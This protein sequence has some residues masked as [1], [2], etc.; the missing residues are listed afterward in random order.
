MDYT[1]LWMKIS[2]MGISKRKLSEM[3][4]LS[5]ASVSY[6]GRKAVRSGTIDRICRALGCGVEDVVR[7]VPD[8]T[9][10]ERVST[11]PARSVPAENDG[12]SEN[13]EKETFSRVQS[14]KPEKAAKK[15]SAK[16]PPKAPPEKYTYAQKEA[17]Y[18]ALGDK[19]FVPMNAYLTEHDVSYTALRDGTGIDVGTLVSFS[20]GSKV[21]S[22]DE[23]GRIVRFLECRL[24]DVCSYTE[25]ST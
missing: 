13:L 11:R 9:V 12:A 24:S 1:P 14:S 6:L 16:V 22:Y 20:S 21:P 10:I 3:T 18:S 15:S 17:A 23:A 25:A 2:S 5:S 8:G 19:S 7:W 4:G